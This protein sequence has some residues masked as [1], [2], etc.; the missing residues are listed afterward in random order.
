M[1]AE[2]RLNAMDGV[3][4]ILRQQ[5]GFRA[6]QIKASRD[7]H[8]GRLTIHK[9]VKR[10][11]GAKIARPA[12]GNK[13]PAVTLRRITKGSRLSRSLRAATPMMRGNQAGCEDIVC[14]DFRSGVDRTEF[15]YQG[16]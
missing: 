13:I 5:E 9:S 11:A 12:V 2:P 3:T 4:G 15:L 8:P 6:E 10:R 1:G 14:G 7:P 16:L